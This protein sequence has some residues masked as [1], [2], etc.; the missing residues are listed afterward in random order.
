M[1]TAQPNSSPRSESPSARPVPSGRSHLRSLLG[2]Q[3]LGTGSYVP[4]NVVPNEALSSLGC[5]PEWIIQ[6][7]GIRERRHAPENIA[8]SDMAFEAAIAALKSAGVDANE[9]DLIVVGTFT[10]DSL[11]PS[12]ACRLQ[13]RLGIRAAAMDVSA[14]CAGFLYAM[15]TAAQFVKTGTSRRALVV[16]ADLLSRIANPHDKKTYPL[17]GDGAGAVVLGPG[18]GEQGMVSY[19]LGSEGEGADMLCVPGGGSKEPLTPENLAEGKQYLHMDG[20]GVFKWAVR[21]IEDSIRDVLY[22]ADLEPEDISLVLLHQA[23]VRIIDAACE[24]LG[25][26][27]EKMIVNL[28]QYGNTSAGSVPIV[29]DEAARKGL[30]Q[31]GDRLLMCGFGAGLSWGTT[32]FQW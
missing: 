9:I 14:A 23:N 7:T 4:D 31:P 13:Q 3:I 32:V 17:F 2:F 1:A 25:F 11:T 18:N 29:L 22:D 26:P 28:D 16:G 21:V 24:N 12:T 8:T 20:R 27:R 5:D 10:P 19:T 15:I 30:I 6:R